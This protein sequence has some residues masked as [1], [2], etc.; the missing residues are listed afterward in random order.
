MGAISTERKLL[1][2]PCACVL[3]FVTFLVRCRP[4]NDVKIYKLFGEFLL[5]LSQ[6]ITP[7]IPVLYSAKMGSKTI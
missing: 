6:T 2:L 1:C 7:V 3:Y 4:E 5:P